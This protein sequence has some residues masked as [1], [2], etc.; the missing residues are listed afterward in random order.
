MNDTT[1]KLEEVIS[2]VIGDKKIKSIFL[3][4]D[5]KTVIKVTRFGKNQRNNVDLR[6]K[7]GR[8]NYAE[9]AYIKKIIKTGG[10]ETGVYKIKFYKN[11][12]ALQ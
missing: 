12:K 8:P 6:I 10:I 2:T 11:K 1:K 5:K 4:L 7:I 9:N 3:I